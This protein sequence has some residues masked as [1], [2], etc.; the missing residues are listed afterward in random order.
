MDLGV[1]EKVAPVLE[2]V[3]NF[4]NEEVIPLEAEYKAEIE[5]GSPWEFTARQTEILGSLKTKARAQ[6]L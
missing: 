4:L 1:S 3:R 5:V 6:G 2:S